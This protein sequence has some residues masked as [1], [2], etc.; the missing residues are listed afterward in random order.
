MH[1]TGLQRLSRPWLPSLLQGYTH[2]RQGQ[3]KLSCHPRNRAHQ[4][5]SRQ[6]TRLPPIGR[7]LKPAH[8]RLLCRPP[9]PLGRLWTQHQALHC[10]SGSTTFFFW[11]KN[12]RKTLIM[13]SKTRNLMFNYIPKLLNTA[14]LIHWNCR[15]SVRNCSDLN[16]FLNSLSLVALCLQET[17]LGPQTKILK[18]K[19]GGCIVYFPV[20]KSPFYFLPMSLLQ[21]CNLYKAKSDVPSCTICCRSQ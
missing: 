21:W 16:D 5:R 4:P 11:D 13:P 15:G 9:A 6:P 2:P 19:L 20:C 1:H 14:F 12:K 3:Q 8:L 17:N 10:C 7:S 18:K